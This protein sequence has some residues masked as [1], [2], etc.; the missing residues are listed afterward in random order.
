MKVE[1]VGKRFRVRKTV[2][3]I[4]YNVTF[5]H[6]PSELEVISA[7]SEKSTTQYKVEETTFEVAA[8]QYIAIKRAVLSP[9]T[10]KGYMYILNNLS[11]P[12]VNK[13][14]NVITHIDVQMEIGKISKD[15]SPKTVRN[16][17]GFISSVMSVYRP[18]FVLNTT[19]PQ[20]EQKEM[21]VPTREEVN[22][23]LNYAKEKRNG[24][25]YVPVMLACYGLRRSEICSLTIDKLNGNELM[26]DTAT[27]LNDKK[28]WVDKTTKT[29]TSTRMVYLSDELANCIREN[30]LYNGHPN[31]I[32]DFIASACKD[33]GIKHFSIHSLRHFFCS[34]LFA[35]NVDA[36]SIMALGGWKTDYVMKSCYRHVVEEK[37]KQ[38]SKTL[39]KILDM[40]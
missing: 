9:S 24:R 17:H 35:N 8:T 10:I 26:I 20:R 4:T 2:D 12:F 1:K 39:I 11:V 36:E 15:R 27:V 19:L 37:K 28:E 3:G 30:G 7:I 25:Y 32:S 18:G 21:Y 29:P 5:N 22:M 6:V 13:D 23:L 38:A 40:N 14:I 33:L 34:Q 16:F 31:G